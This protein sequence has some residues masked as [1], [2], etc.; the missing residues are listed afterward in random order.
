MV[1]SPV[2][3]S[4]FVACCAAL[5]GILIC[6]CRAAEAVAQKAEAAVS[7]L[8]VSPSYYYDWQHQP[9]T[10]DPRFPGGHLPSGRDSPLVYLNGECMNGKLYRFASGKNG[11]V[12]RW[13]TT[14]DGRLE[15]HPLTKR[16][17]RQVLI[18]NVTVVPRE[19]V[20]GIAAADG[21]G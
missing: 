6:R 17:W 1:I 20:F 9:M 3:L 21:E 15:P 5:I 7:Q 13:A 18:G 11:Y 19:A 2:L 14:P 10:N 4:L 8:E 12:E 16:A